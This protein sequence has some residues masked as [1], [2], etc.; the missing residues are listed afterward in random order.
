MFTRNSNILGEV[1]A[2]PVTVVCTRCCTSGEIVASLDNDEVIDP[3]F[4]LDLRGLSASI[5][6]DVLAMGEATFTIP[7]LASPG[8]LVSSVLRGFEAGL[9]FGLDLVF[10]FSGA[11]NAKGGFVIDF[12]DNAFFEVSVFDGAMTDFSLWVYAIF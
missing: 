11:L 4:R 8:K 9:D 6:L 12:P 10:T 5:E 2:P 1:G 3:T 7:L